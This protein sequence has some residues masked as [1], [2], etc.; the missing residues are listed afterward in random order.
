MRVRIAIL[1]FVIGWAAQPGDLRGQDLSAA[2]ADYDVRLEKG[3]ELYSQSK[4]AEAEVFFL[5]LTNSAAARK[6]AYLW[7]GHALSKQGKW[8][9]ARDALKR[10]GEL[11]P[12]DT[13]GLIQTAR[14]YEAENNKAL[15]KLWYKK[16][17]DRDPKSEQIRKAL[18]QLDHEGAVV[19]P[20]PEAANHQSN[21]NN[22]PPSDATFW[23]TGLAGV[24]GARS[25]WWGR[26]IVL[27]F[28]VMGIVGGWN[29]VA[30][31]RE[32]H[33]LLPP[34]GFFL[35]AAFGAVVSYVLLWGIPAGWNW[36]WLGAFVT[37]NV[38]GTAGAIN[39]SPQP[40]RI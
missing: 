33:P 9:Q 14:S 17:Q 21:S 39:A 8:A 20:P 1:F 13:E 29:N 35:A 36:A 28:M 16:A 24:T 40:S 30:R 19:V 15:A 26:A 4:Y 23:N 22:S 37:L 34:F 2:N 18:E 31:M 7:L 38:L 6:E 11:A 10:Y 3:V 27:M 12:N 25:V 5:N 32:R